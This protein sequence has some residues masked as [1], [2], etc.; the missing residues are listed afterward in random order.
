MRLEKYQALSAA[1][2]LGLGTSLPC[3]VQAA[4]G[5]KW[6]A[7]SKRIQLY[8]QLRAS[9]D[10][11]SGDLAKTTQKGTGLNSNASRIGIKG[12]VP[13]NMGDTSLIYQAEIR[14]DTTNEV[15]TDQFNLR[16]GYAGLK[17]KSWGKLRLG[18][19]SVGYKTTLTKID[20]WNDNIPQ[21]RSG[22][23]QGSS[24]F[25]SSYFNSA[26][27]YV[28]PKIA[29]GLTFNGW[30]SIQPEQSTT[31]LHNTSTLKNYI[32]GTAGGI[33]AKYKNGN[34]FLGMDY[35]KMDATSTKNATSGLQN[36]S[37]WQIGGRY[38]FGAFSISGL[39]ENVDDLGLGKNA[40]VNVIWKISHMRLIAA[41]GQN[42]DADVYGNKDWNNWSLGAKY[43]LTKKSELLLAYNSRTDA[44]NSQSLNAVTLG[45]N[46]KFGY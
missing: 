18:R 10:N 12:V 29:G 27:D 11:F 7:N 34:L 30:A 13:T 43:N 26:V 22:G 36:G 23:R 16:E 2:V 17:S 45:I 3:T 46:A 31:P 1:V 42:R 41:Y 15:K 44:T 8:G 39:Y 20:P 19:L 9:V 37:G 21:S 5:Q 4:D 33:G 32:G 24:E 25:H 28:T 6:D 14:Y 35:I 38:K 40:Y